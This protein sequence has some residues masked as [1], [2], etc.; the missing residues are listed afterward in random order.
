MK[1]SKISLM[2]AALLLVGCNTTSKSSLPS[3]DSSADSGSS[4]DYSSSK[5]DSVLQE[6][7]VK[8]INNMN[9]YLGEELAVPDIPT[10][11]KF[12]DHS[13]D[14]YRYVDI[15][16][17][18]YENYMEEYASVLESEGFTL[19]TNGET[20][21]GFIVEGENVTDEKGT[22][23]LYELEKGPF[24]IA[25]TVSENDLAYE[26]DGEYYYLSLAGNEI[27]ANNALFTGSESAWPSDALKEYTGLDIPSI[28]ANSYDIVDYRDYGYGYYVLAYLDSETIEED[29]KAKLEALKFTV[30]YD[31]NNEIYVAVSENGNIQIGFY[32][33][34]EE[35][36]FVLNVLYAEQIVEWPVDELKAYCGLE[37]P[38]PEADSYEIDDYTEYGY[39]YFIYAYLDSETIEE[40]YKAKLEALKF[41]VTYD[42]DEE[43]YLATSES[44]EV[45]V[46][47]Y[48]NETDSYLTI[49]VL[50]VEK[51]VAWPSEEIA[52]LFDGAIVPSFPGVDDYYIDDTN[53]EE[54]GYTIYFDASNLTD[55]ETTYENTLTEAGFTI[56]YDEDLECNLAYS[57][58]GKIVVGAYQ[59]GET[60]YIQISEVEE[61]VIEA[62]VLDFSTAELITK[63]DADESIWENGEYKMVV[64]KGSS[65]Q[66]V[67]NNQYYSDPLRL[68]KGQHVVLTW[69]SNE[70]TSITINCNLEGSKS[71][72][73]N[74]INFIG[75]TATI[76]DNAIII[77]LDEGATEVS[78]DI[79][80]VNSTQLHIDSIVF[81]A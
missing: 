51:P 49:I 78:F 31:E 59:F 20:Q 67:G 5:N 74:A 30:T 63:K 34:T 28:E 54:Y 79:G 39:G 11:V 75:G 53:I 80:S 15:V 9:A 19:T 14:E 81:N 10:T 37:L 46:G 56:E 52:T 29:Y 8:T 61:F 72:I 7:P 25:L 58:D 13:D 66:G 12:T 45:Q 47:F 33:S 4:S 22:C 62:N 64:T 70:V 77:T 50:V 65:S 38:S 76:K 60:F 57:A 21:E 1:F 71:K 36:C 69:G 42:E 23:I 17:D 26:S 68:Y 27:Y 73:E 40:D 18:T 55:A 35:Y 48:Y 41:T 24:Y 2:L 43:M 6:W 32:Y 44:D 16:F 3:S